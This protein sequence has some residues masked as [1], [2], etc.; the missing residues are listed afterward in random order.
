VKLYGSPICD[1][2]ERQAVADNKIS[3]VFDKNGNFKR[4]NFR[5]RR[6]N[7]RRVAVKRKLIGYISFIRGENPRFPYRIALS[8]FSPL[9]TFF[10][11]KLRIQCNKPVDTPL[12]LL[13][14]GYMTKLGT[15]RNRILRHSEQNVSHGKSPNSARTA[16]RMATPTPN[17]LIWWNL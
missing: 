13:V 14:Y 15:P 3:D 10:L 11:R 8:L 16:M 9:K 4:T 17:T 12:N 7:G 6:N 2:L 1:E 5:R